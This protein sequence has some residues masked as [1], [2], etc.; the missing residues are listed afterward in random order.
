[1]SEDYF[2]P[3]EAGKLLGRNGLN[4]FDA[5]WDLELDAVDAPNTNRGGWS[6]V[7]RLELADDE[8]N[9]HGYYLKRQDNHLTRSWIKPFGEPTFAREYRAIQAYARVKV[10]AVEAVAFAQRQSG[11]HHQAILVTKA[12]DDHE[13]LDLWLHRWETLS[14]KDKAIIVQAVALL[15]R[16]LHEVGKIHNC[17][18]AKHIFVKLDDSGATARLIDLEKT[19]SVL[20]GQN[21]L[22]SDLSTLCRRTPTPSRTQRLRFLLLYL[23]KQRVDKEA[24]SWVGQIQK[25]IQRKAAT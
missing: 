9:S 4:S 5:L 13:P 10:P 12:L 14:W 1:M 20:F 8:G 21:D 15:V 18:Y 3:S 2:A 17:L 24:R 7:Y 11:G 22:V 16:R 19:R 23:D 25:R 6:T